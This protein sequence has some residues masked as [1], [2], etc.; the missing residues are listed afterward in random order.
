MG[1]GVTASRSE[2]LQKKVKKWDPPRQRRGRPGKRQET[3]AVRGLWGRV[4]C[5]PQSRVCLGPETARLTADTLQS[6]L[7]APGLSKC[8][9]LTYAALESEP[10]PGWP[11]HHP[12]RDSLLPKFMQITDHWTQTPPHP[13]FQ[14][15]WR[16]CLSNKAPRCYK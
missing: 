6:K 3:A 15:R 13:A 14:P 10:R 4:T 7:L 8:S 2:L 12:G 1:S 9:V 16:T 11:G 5:R